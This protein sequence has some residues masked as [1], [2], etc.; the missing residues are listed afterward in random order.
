M[1]SCHY[2]VR[3]VGSL[4]AF[5]FFLRAGNG[6]VEKAIVKVMV[7]HVWKVVE[8]SLCGGNVVMMLM[9]LRFEVA[10]LLLACQGS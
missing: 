6:A 7:R 5:A 4:G 2:F 3:D 8:S 10:P 9:M 1:Y